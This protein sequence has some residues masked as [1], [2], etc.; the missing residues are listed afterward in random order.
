MPSLLRWYA[1]CSAAYSLWMP[2]LWT[3]VPFRWPTLKT[4]SRLAPAH[5]CCSSA[6]LDAPRSVPASRCHPHHCCI[7]ASRAV[8]RHV[9]N[10]YVQPDNT[11]TALGGE[12]GVH[13]RESIRLEVPVADVYR[14]WRR[15]ENL[16]RFMTHLDRVTESLGRHVALGGRRVQPGWPSSGTPRSSTRSRTRCS[17]GGRFPDLTS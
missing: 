10:G 6:R 9:L 12:R 3:T 17:R 4:G 16:P 8:G 11:K 15:L 14:F 7:A 2:K 13:V 1:K 5:C